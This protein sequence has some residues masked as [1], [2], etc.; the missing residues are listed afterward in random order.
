MLSITHERNVPLAD[1]IVPGQNESASPSFQLRRS[2]STNRNWSSKMGLVRQLFGKSASPLVP[3]PEPTPASTPAPTLGS[4]PTSAPAPTPV[5]EPSETP[6]PIYVI[7][8][9]AGIAVDLSHQ[10]AN[11]KHPANHAAELLY[12]LMHDDAIS[13]GPALEKVV[14]KYYRM[15]CSNPL[16]WPSVLLHLNRILKE[17]YGTTSFKTYK[18]VNKGRRRRRL[19]VYHIP[20]A[21][22]AAQTPE[23]EVIANV[24]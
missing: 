4:T 22:G 23:D 19:R 15:M 21:E 20:R 7:R 1:L 12:A 9:A 16:P 8:D 10:C 24:A 17:V 18:W 6:P 11:P 5:S 14:K 2:W 13:G 3:A